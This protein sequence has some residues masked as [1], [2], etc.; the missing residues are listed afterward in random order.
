MVGPPVILAL[1]RCNIELWVFC[2]VAT[3]VMLGA[4]EGRFGL[5]VRSL[6]LL[7]AA[8]GKLYPVGSFLCL[9]QDSLKKTFIAVG[10]FLGVVGLYFALTLSDIRRIAQLLPQV[11]WFSYGGRIAFEYVMALLPHTIRTGALGWISQL[12]YVFVICT[13]ASITFFV[14]SKRTC[15]GWSGFGDVPQSLFLAA[16][17]VFIFS[18]AVLKSYEYR[19]VFLLL[20]LPFLFSMSRRGGEARMISWTT[21][22]TVFVLF[23]GSEFYGLLPATARSGRYVNWFFTLVNLGASWLL[24]VLM[25]AMIGGVVCSWFLFVTRP[26]DSRLSSTDRTGEVLL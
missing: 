26:A 23:F 6:C 10:I 7:V 18:F 13:V 9:L 12:V 1:E 14:F 2:L 25:L 11:E 16:G 8:M 21:L 3:G 4:R 22:S 15:F 5:P 19:Y 20:C 17:G 24:F